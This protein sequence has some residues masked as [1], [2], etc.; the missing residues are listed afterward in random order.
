MLQIPGNS[1][2]TSVLE[3]LLPPATTKVKHLPYRPSRNLALLLWPERRR[4][5]HPLSSIFFV[6]ICGIREH[7]AK[8]RLARSAYRPRSPNIMT[9]GGDR[10][11]TSSISHT[12][13]L[14][15]HACLLLNSWLGLRLTTPS[16]M[17]ST[18]C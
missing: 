9:I 12:P 11:K 17:C 10:A 3:T 1:A 7:F 15:L 5:P 4:P 6:K 13:S 18:C 14:I 16:F 2:E 8:I